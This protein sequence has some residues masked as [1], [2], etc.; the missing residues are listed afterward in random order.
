MNQKA[1][2]HLKIDTGMQRIGVQ[3]TNA[4]DFYEHVQALDHIQIKGIYSHFADADNEENLD[5]VNIQIK[6]FEEVIKSIEQRFDLSRIIKH[7]ANGSA[8]IK[9][10]ESLFD[11]ARVGLAT[12]GLYPDKSCKK[13]ITLYPVLGM[14]SQV[15]YFKVVPKN[16]SIGYNRT[17]YTT[18]ET[19]IVTIPVGYGDGLDKRLSNKGKVIINGEIHNM[20]GKI[21]MDQFMVDIGKDGEA[22]N[23][24]EVVIIGKQKDKEITLEQICD[25]CDIDPFEFLCRLTTRIPRMYHSSSN[26]I[27]SKSFL[28]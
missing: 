2:V 19:R 14:K 24:D 12:Y 5:F 16:T 17:Y 9:V 26:D 23:D 11:M 4:I 1:I 22:Y 8:A 20:V 3:Y 25:E 6:L 27:Y 18:E 21:N 10:K 7:I 28:D 15:V 13:H